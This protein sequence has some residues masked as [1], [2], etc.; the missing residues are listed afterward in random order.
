MEEEK[1]YYKKEYEALKAS[2]RSTPP[3]KIV[4]KKVSGKLNEHSEYV[5]GNEWM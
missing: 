3:V 1:D 4:P 2:R 5:G